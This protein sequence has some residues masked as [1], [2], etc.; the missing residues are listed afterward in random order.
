MRA[1]KPI[2][3]AA[4]LTKINLSTLYRALK[5]HQKTPVREQGKAK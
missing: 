1:G 3:A 4:K 2:K 5:R